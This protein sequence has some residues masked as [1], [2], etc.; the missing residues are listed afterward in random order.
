MVRPGTNAKRGPALLARNADL[1]GFL[2]DWP[3][4]LLGH[5]PVQPMCRGSAVYSRGLGLGHYVQDRVPASG[6]PPLLHVCRRL[7]LAYEPQRESIGVQAGK[8]LQKSH[9]HHGQ[10]RVML[11]IAQ[12]GPHSEKEHCLPLT[13]K[14]GVLA[15]NGTE[16]R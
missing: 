14:R 12:S 6:R 4:A 3:H 8:G 1:P 2:P 10:P 15:P 9:D 5:W 16:P 7:G 13:P 11:A